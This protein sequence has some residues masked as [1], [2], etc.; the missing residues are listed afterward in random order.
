LVAIDA[1]A[2]W[3]ER[4]WRNCA[5]ARDPAGRHAVGADRL[6][7]GVRKAKGALRL[8]RLG[9]LIDPL[10]A[11]KVAEA[12]RV[13]KGVPKGQRQPVDRGGLLVEVAVAEVVARVDFG[14]RA[15]V[16]QALEIRHAV[17]RDVVVLLVDMCERDLGRPV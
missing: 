3:Q 9:D 16:H 17:D 11:G 13:R 1:A 10:P 4:A 5:G 8:A 14:Q 2:G 6:E 15:V 7:A 12:D